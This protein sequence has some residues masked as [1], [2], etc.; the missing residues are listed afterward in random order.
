MYGTGPYL[1][2]C[3]IKHSG[4]STMAAF[5][6]EET[7][8]VRFDTDELILNSFPDSDTIRNVYHILGK[9]SFMAAEAAALSTLVGFV[10]DTTWKGFQGI[11]SLG[12]GACDNTRVMDFT[13]AS[14]TMIYLAAPEDVLFARI[15]AG[16]IPPFLDSDHPRESFR[17]LYAL[18]DARYRKHA[19]F[20]VELPDCHD[21]RDTFRY[22]FEQLSDYVD[23]LSIPEK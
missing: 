5:M 3:G 12:G 23:T 1:F 10:P 20:V 15:T 8:L 17:Q 4:K 18:R 6:A 19:H 13:G 16:G 2:F 22:L 21:S 7:G 11:V 14:G 9:E